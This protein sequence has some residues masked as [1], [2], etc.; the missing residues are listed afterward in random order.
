LAAG[1]SSSQWRLRVF[2]GG[3]NTDGGCAEA[4]KRN[5]AEATP[6]ER[7]SIVVE[8]ALGSGSATA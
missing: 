2:G 8:A 1:S 5:A 7:A 3:T 4:V 6:L